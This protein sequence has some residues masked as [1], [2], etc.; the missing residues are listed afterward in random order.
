M[1]AMVEASRLL[2]NYI[3]QYHNLP[4]AIVHSESKVD[5][6]QALINTREKKDINIF[7]EFMKSTITD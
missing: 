1:M 5:Y 4:E 6:I 2:M 7:R 3:Q